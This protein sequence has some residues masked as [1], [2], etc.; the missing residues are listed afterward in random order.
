MI[1]K[2][3]C[4]C[5]DINFE[6]TSNLAVIKQCN[7]SICKRKFAK[8]III[9]KNHLK[10]TKGE[11]NLSSYKFGTNVATHFFCKKCGIYTHHYR[12]SDPTGAGV[13]SGCIDNIDPFSISSEVLN[14]K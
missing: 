11:E 4:H 3:S 6:I 2:G 1:Y 9:P 7:C 12:K 8:M 10:I 13:N 14:N 5:G